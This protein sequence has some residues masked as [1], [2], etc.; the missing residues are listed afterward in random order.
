MQ[1]LVHGGDWTNRL[2]LL[3][4]L[5]LFSGVSQEDAARVAT[6]LSE[7]E[8]HVGD[9]ITLRPTGEAVY[10]VKSGRVRLESG[11]VAVGVLGPGQLFGTS[12]LFGAPAAEERAVALEEVVLCEAPAGQFLMAMSSHPVLASRVAQLLARQLHEL[13]QSMRHAAE[14][15]VEARLAAL[16]L[17][18]ADGD[19]RREIHGLSQEELARLIGASRHRVTRVL[20]GW[21]RDGL[22]RT[23]HRA[24]RVMDTE[25]LRKRVAGERVLNAPAQS[26]RSGSGGTMRS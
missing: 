18:L 24:L 5:E 19:D 17:Q 4:Q 15:P 1:H 23:R 20:A 11:N 10:I 3:K 16:V 9:D 6:V 13:Q 26:G 8:C 7:R 22:V 12:S 14:D 21:E 2:W 25:E